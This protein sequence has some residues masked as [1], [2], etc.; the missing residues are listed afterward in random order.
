MTYGRNYPQNCGTDD[1]NND[2]NNDG[3]NA[4][5]C[6]QETHVQICFFACMKEKKSFRFVLV[7]NN[8]HHTGDVIKLKVEKV[9]QEG[10]QQQ[11][12]MFQDPISSSITKQCLTWAYD[13]ARWMDEWTGG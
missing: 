10:L 1:E 3:K 4:H 2:G 13:I 12:I 8:H 7:Q 6:T 5:M 9:A 11:G